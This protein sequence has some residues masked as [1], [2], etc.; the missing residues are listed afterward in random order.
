M[1]GCPHVEA[2]KVYLLY[3]LVVTCRGELFNVC[4]QGF[5]G[6]VLC[7]FYLCSGVCR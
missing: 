7:V 3:K 4:P 1:L 2:S 6:T 5:L